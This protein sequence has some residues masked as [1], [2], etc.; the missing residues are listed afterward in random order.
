MAEPARPEVRYRGFLSYSHKDAAAGGRLHRRLEAY[1]L[2]KRLVGSATARGIVPDRLWPIFRDRDELPAASDLTETVR[3]ALAQS[4]ALIVL[5]SPRSAES[6]W[7]AEEIETFRALHPDRPILAA[8]LDG[9]PPSCFPAALRSLG[10]N[11]TWHEPLA[12][13][14]RPQGDGARLGLLKLVAGITGVGLD[15]L[16]QRDAS[17]RIRR[18]MAV[19]GAAVIAMLAMAALA[20]VAINARAEAERQRA[21]A[22]GMAGFMLTDLRERLREVGR[23]DIMR[24][25]NRRALSYYD[26][27]LERGDRSAQILLQRARVQQAIGEDYVDQGRLDE[28][29]AI[30]TEA[31]RATAEQLAQ[32]PDDLQRLLD[33]AHSDYWLGRIYELRQDWPAAER[34][35]D[36]FAHATSR[37]IARAPRNVDYMIEAGWSAV[38]QG[39]IRLYRPAPSDPRPAASAEERVREAARAKAID[40]AA[41]ESLYRLA[42]NRFALASTSR[43]LRRREDALRAQSNAYGYLADTF[44]YREMW[45]DSLRERLSQLTIV[46]RLQRENPGDLRTRYRLAL[47]QSAVARSYGRVGDRVEAERLLFTAHAWSKRLVEL[48]PDNAEWRLFRV[49]VGCQLYF[50]HRDLHFAFPAGLSAGAE[51]DDIRRSGAL[52]GSRVAPAQHCLDNLH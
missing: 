51:R 48:D 32:A 52:L 12:T 15:E 24:A 49:I 35:Y 2:P 39:N 28:A 9:D 11:G 4:G 27:E 30:F 31:H 1:R 37:L 13:D 7:V 26:L 21:E 50:G 41:A 16:V 23:L 22:E 3:E 45:Q 6:L 19:T 20:L 29:F 36:R 46:E 44:F 43:S 34:Q 14:L 5:C 10:S 25:A 38:D 42:V 40:Y 8:I 17:R 47:A 18:V 33:H